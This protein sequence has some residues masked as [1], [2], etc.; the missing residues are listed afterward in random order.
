MLSTRFYIVRLSYTSSSAL[1]F[2]C[3]SCNSCNT[4]YSATALGRAVGVFWLV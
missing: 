4:R 3:N 1:L 2:H